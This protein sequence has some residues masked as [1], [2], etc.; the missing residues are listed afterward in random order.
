MGHYTRRNR[1]S[2]VPTGQTTQ[3]GDALGRTVKPTFQARHASSISPPAPRERP[4]RR[5]FFVLPPCGAARAIRLGAIARPTSSGGH[6]QT[7]ELQ[8]F[9]Y[10]LATMCALSP[11]VI[12]M[13][14]NTAFS[15]HPGTAQQHLDGAVTDDHAIAG[16]GRAPESIATRSD[17][18]NADCLPSSATEPSRDRTL[19]RRPGAVG[20]SRGTQRCLAW[21]RLSSMSRI[22][23]PVL[24]S[25]ATG[26]SQRSCGS[27]RA[28]DALC[29]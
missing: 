11:R 12:S 19:T 13:M 2:A 21:A 18:R 7:P 29:G 26:L 9:R 4:S 3:S 15:T 5:A 17:P 28:S 22:A 25:A 8:L 16:F 20:W 6:R 23:S 1:S 27:G 14:W 24:G 10:V